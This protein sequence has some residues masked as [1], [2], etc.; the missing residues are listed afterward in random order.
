MKALLIATANKQP[1]ID[2]PLPDSTTSPVGDI[3]VSGSIGLGLGVLIVREIVKS[4]SD[5]WQ[6]RLELSK[7]EE[8]AEIAEDQAD[9]AMLQEMIKDLREQNKVL[10]DQNQTLVLEI[11]QL[12]RMMEMS[13]PVTPPLPK[14]S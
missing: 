11:C 10:R 4:V 9:R 6:H 3:L 13:G 14:Q 5:W 12:R 8:M 2:I 1:D 7:A